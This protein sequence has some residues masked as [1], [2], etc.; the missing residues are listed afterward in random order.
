MASNYEIKFNRKGDSH[1]I[2]QDGL[3]FGQGVLFVDDK[4]KVLENRALHFLLIPV[5]DA[6]PTQ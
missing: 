4:I 6:T 3:V 5:T 2:Y 1:R